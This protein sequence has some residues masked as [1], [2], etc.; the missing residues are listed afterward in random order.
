MANLK[1]NEN[2]FPVLYLIVPCY[3]E[4]EMLPETNKQ[5]G[6]LLSMMITNHVID[7]KSRIVYVDDGSEDGTWGL[8]EKFHQKS[9]IVNGV[10]LAGNSG[11]QSA[12]VAGLTIAKEYANVMITIDA[13]LQDDIHAIPTMIDKYREGCDIVY[14]V[15]SSRKSDS[16]LKRN[17]ALTFYKIMFY[18]GAKSIYNHADFRLMSKRAVEQ[19][20]LY[21]ERNLFLRGIVPLI[22]YR[23]E[24][25]YYER[26]ERLA[27]KSK[28]S[29]AKM[30]NFA[31]DGITS[32][33]VKPVRLIFNL[34]LVFIFIAIC[35]LVYVLHAYFRG[36]T[37]PGWS[38]LILSMW[39]IGGCV[40]VGLG[41][42]GEYIGKIYLEVKDRP[43]YVIEKE[44]K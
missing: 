25:I 28:Y 2:E 22:G 41:I 6:A 32:F 42:V 19:L 11:H 8:I 20:L 16:F 26:K 30:L 13:D 14:G 37:M 18:L 24:Q 5:L 43:R 10:K 34:G 3:N 21:R 4:R 39:F 40:L 44:L 17:S 27:G 1:E 29:F 7:S 35:I 31:T 38:S 12:L 33:S 9:E 36:N 23:S 15:R